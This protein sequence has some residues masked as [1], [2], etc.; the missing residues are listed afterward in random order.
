MKKYLFFTLI[1]SFFIS[2]LYA[3]KPRNSFFNNIQQSSS[4]K[5]KMPFE[6]LT[7]LS[8]DGTKIAKINAI[9][10][11]IQIIDA[12]QSH[13]DQLAIIQ[14]IDL[15]NH[16]TED[17]PS[18]F[19][20]PE[21][22]CNDEAL[23]VHK[24]IKKPKDNSSSSQ[25]ILI[26]L[27]T[28]VFTPLLK[29]N[30]YPDQYHFSNLNSDE[31]FIVTAPAYFKYLENLQKSGNL[32]EKTYALSMKSIIEK[33]IKNNLS[34][35]EYFNTIIEKI[36]G[37]CSPV[38]YFNALKGKAKEENS[39]EENS[40]SA[41]INNIAKTLE[42]LPFTTVM[43]KTLI[44]PI[45]KGIEEAEKSLAE[46][47]KKLLEINQKIDAL[48]I[49]EDD[50]AVLEKEYEKKFKAR[51]K[52]SKKLETPK[53]KIFKINLRTFKRTLIDTYPYGRTS[54]V[55]NSKD[56]IIGAEDIK[57]QKPYGTETRISIKTGKR[58]KK[59][60]DISL[61]D[62]K[63]KKY[64]YLSNDAQKLYYVSSEFTNYKAAY[65]LDI[66]SGASKKLL[67][68]P[69]ADIKDFVIINK[70][71]QPKLHRFDS[72]ILYKICKN[73][74]K[75]FSNN[76][77]LQNLLDHVNNLETT[78][79]EDCMS[80]ET[81]MTLVQGNIFKEPGMFYLYDFRNLL[82]DNLLDKIKA[83][84]KI[85]LFPEGKILAENLSPMNAYQIKSRDGLELNF[86]VT[87]P[88]TKKGT[89]YPFIVNVHGGPQL[90]DKIS[91]NPE[92][93]FWADRE[94]GTVR[95]NFR[96]STGYG[97]DF[98][99][100]GEGEWGAKMIDD[101][102]DVVIHLIKQNIIDKDRVVISG[103]SYGGNAVYSALAF[104]PDLFI[105]GMAGAGDAD[106]FKTIKLE[107]SEPLKTH[108]KTLMFGDPT[109][110]KKDMLKAS[111]IRSPL[112]HVEHIKVPLLIISPVE[113]K[114]V[115]YKQTELM[116]KAL[117]AHDK[118]YVA[119]K[120]NKAGHDMGSIE[121]HIAL[122]AIQEEFLKH[123]FKLEE[124]EPIGDALEKAPDIVWVD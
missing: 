18:E 28:E 101:I 81:F 29:E 85:E 61:E 116:L 9:E 45:K 64:L 14:E 62:S 121:N 54:I 35:I 41:I 67:E 19:S 33:S 84:K 100:A 106:L 75:V 80:S 86:Y 27:K 110:S 117:K 24:I 115:F 53:L 30:E 65:E 68:H 8:K 124:T 92:D 118:E 40:I 13:N 47:E 51:D 36:E 63:D 98:L 111:L 55:F 104:K 114:I 66:Q 73:I 96:G 71:E 112:H 91:L 42:K 4:A 90:H 50:P 12:E 48:N 44:N 77:E 16:I 105:A 11:K 1:I 49:A 94:I 82:L 20:S 76:D 31:I 122:L 97:K 6:G 95:I 70:Q 89:S 107:P 32:R 87:L 57:K 60:F 37:G 113:D 88:K 21:F 99:E 119:Y 7:G 56:Q 26:D 102:E 15:S 25:L 69:D 123:I 23:I 34:L 5:P 46:N 59:I 38:E 52:L 58:W 72:A 74:P 17:N 2:E 10:K 39:I 83:P 103:F 79:L 120:I 109:I 78:H 93:Q 43:G 22:V 108:W 3:V